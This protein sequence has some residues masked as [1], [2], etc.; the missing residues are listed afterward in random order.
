MSPVPNCESIYALVDSLDTEPTPDQRAQ[1]ERHLAV[2]DHCRR[3]LAFVE[4]TAAIWSAAATPVPHPALA[5]RLRAAVAA[6]RRRSLVERLSDWVSVPV[7]AYGAVAAA[8]ALVALVGGLGDA[9]PPPTRAAASLVALADSSLPRPV[10]T[11]ADSDNVLAN[12]RLLDLS[13][14]E[15]RTDSLDRA[16]LPGRRL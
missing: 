15:P 13:G 14:S 3:D 5:V 9:A 6:R 7:P 8:L 16:A 4:R 10:L 1:I 2:C 12:I 11:R